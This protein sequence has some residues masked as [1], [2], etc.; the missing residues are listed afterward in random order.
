[1]RGLVKQLQINGA[2]TEFGI[3]VTCEEERID[4]AAVAYDEFRD[5]ITGRRLDIAAVHEARQ[6]EIDITRKMEVFEECDIEECWTETGAPPIGVI[7]FEVDKGD[8][9]RPEIISRLVAREL[10]SKQSREGIARGDV[11]PATPLP[12]GAKLLLSMMMTDRPAVPRAMG[13]T[14][15]GGAAAADGDRRGG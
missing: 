14:Q 6:E 5:N 8:V 10:K 15:G 13:D 4:W 2:L 9:D 11:F 7:W 12:Q 1:M 3:G